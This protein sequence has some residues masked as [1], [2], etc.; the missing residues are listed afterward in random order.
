MLVLVNQ[1]RQELEHH[2]HGDIVDVHVR[3]TQ[4]GRGASPRSSQSSDE[5]G[6][7]RHE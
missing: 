2:G 1:P 3:S 5:E 4:H 6:G 7:R